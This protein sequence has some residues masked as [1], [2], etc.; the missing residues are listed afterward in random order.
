MFV[1]HGLQTTKVINMQSS[2][3]TNNIEIK[4]EHWSLKH[5]ISSV[6]QEQEYR[7][8][9]NDLISGEI[10]QP[11]PTTRG[12]SSRLKI[13]QRL[14]GEIK[15]VISRVLKND[16]TQG[17]DNTDIKSCLSNDDVSGRVIKQG[18]DEMRSD[19]KGINRVIKQR[20]MISKVIKQ[21]QG[22]IRRIKRKWWALNHHKYDVLGRCFCISS[23]YTANTQEL[24]FAPRM[25]YQRLR[26]SS[27]NCD[28]DSN[29]NDGSNANYSVANPNAASNSDDTVVVN[30]GIIGD[31]DTGK[32]SFMVII[33][34]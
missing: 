14:K 18:S 2:N 15:E 30:I 24:I 11:S 6:I 31:S 29:P 32:T 23:D 9:D 34:V 25:K 20:G 17:H 21:G 4:Q 26:S 33:F 27:S 3:K 8:S 10:K 1:S 7:S 13:T 16:N 22:V 28:V 19:G 5:M 12:S